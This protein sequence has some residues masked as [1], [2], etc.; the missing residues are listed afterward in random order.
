MPATVICHCF[1][2]SQS[3]MH[4]K[5]S[6]VRIVGGG[7]RG[8]LKIVGKVRG[9]GGVRRGLLQCSSLCGAH[10][11]VRPICFQAVHVLD[12]GSTE[13]TLQALCSLCKLG[14]QMHVPGHQLVCCAVRPGP[15]GAPLVPLDVEPPQP[16]PRPLPLGALRFAGGATL[17]CCLGRK[18][19]LRCMTPSC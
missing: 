16:R 6:C 19:G 10:S 11:D 14:C 18:S 2:N 9:M 3:K 8:S 4:S 7:V 17:L 12:R 5:G 13:I 15:R 1:E